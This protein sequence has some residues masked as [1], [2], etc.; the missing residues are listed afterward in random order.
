MGE[1]WL[2]STFI[3]LTL[4]LR[5]LR[6]IANVSHI[7]IK[8]TNS[9]SK[10]ALYW[11][12]SQ[13]K[14]KINLVRGLLFPFGC[15]SFTKGK[16]AIPVIR[17]IVLW[18]RY[19]GLL[20]GFYITVLVGWAPVFNSRGRWQNIKESSKTKTCRLAAWNKRIPTKAIVCFQSKYS[21]LGFIRIYWTEVH[22]CY[23]CFTWMVCCYFTWAC[24]RIG[25]YL[26]M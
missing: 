21:P 22:F 9:V 13:L 10:V 20:A 16:C 24:S 26:H 18:Q 3:N 19:S 23:S 7:G 6:L 12:L 11:T 15:D 1:W 25:V 5:H 17:W 2:F 4:Q 14:L 8:V